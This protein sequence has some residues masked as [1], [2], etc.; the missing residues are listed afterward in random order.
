MSIPYNIA[1]G[2]VVDETIIS[3]SRFICYLRPCSSSADAKAFIKSLQLKHPQANH[4]CYAFIAGRPENSQLYGF[5]DDGEPSGTAGKPMLTMLMGS[6]LGEICAVVVRY[7]GGTK[8]GPGGLQRAYG[9]SVKQALAL[10]PTK[11]K[12]PMVRKTLACQYNQ[13][14]DVLYLLSQH[15]GEVIQ[16]DYREDIVLNLALPAE[17]LDAFQQQLQTMSAGQ[18]TLQSIA[19]SNNK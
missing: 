1:A 4:H 11:L 5:S 10:L 15:G 12:I 18:L 6:E 2:E 14:N 19:K 3:R 17:K 8:L 7:F 16:Q 9:G 13:I